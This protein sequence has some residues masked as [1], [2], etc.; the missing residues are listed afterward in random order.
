LGGIVS[1]VFIHFQ[2]ICSC[3][4]SA[5]AKLAYLVYLFLGTMMFTHRNPE[6]LGGGE[7]FGRVAF[8]IIH[9]GLKPRQ[10]QHCGI[11]IFIRIT[12][13]TKM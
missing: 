11:G 3:N 12:S 5:K 7:F 6:A 10:A 1:S 4:F 13:M 9:G 8:R 2:S